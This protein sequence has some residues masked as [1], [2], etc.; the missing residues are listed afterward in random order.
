M[1]RHPRR[2]GRN[3]PAVEQ[4][5]ARRNG[6]T[7]DRDR[8]SKNPRA[9]EVARQA[10]IALY[11]PPSRSWR[12]VGFGAISTLKSEEPIYLKAIWWK[13]NSASRYSRKKKNNGVAGSL[14]RQR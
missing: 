10:K 13:T 2:L 5:P 12:R 7:P 3:W 9:A 11:Q 14:P 1:L 4:H 8:Q 6:A